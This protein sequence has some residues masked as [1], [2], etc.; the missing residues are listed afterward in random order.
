[1]HEGEGTSC[2]KV[3]LIRDFWLGNHA[4]GNQTIGI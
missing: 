2:G 3:T 1:M 4:I